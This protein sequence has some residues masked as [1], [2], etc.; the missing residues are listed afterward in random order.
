MSKIV[1]PIEA[2]RPAGWQNTMPQADSIFEIEEEDAYR[3]PNVVI[4][5]ADDLGFNDVSFYGGGVY[6][7]NVT[8]PNIDSIGHDGVSFSTAYAGHATC[9]P[10][11]A[12]LLTGRYPS[13][14]GFEFTPTHPGYV[15]ILGTSSK[16]IRKGLYY[17]EKAKGLTLEN[18]SLPS[19]TV[20]LS[21]AFKNKGYKSLMIG[22]YHLGENPL[23]HGFDETL[24]FNIISSYLPSGHKDLETFPLP[25]MLDK[26]LCANVACSVKKNG[27][28]KRF[29]PNQYMTDYFAEEAVNAIRANKEHPF[30]LYLP[31][32]APHTPLQAFKADFDS[33]SHIP[34]RL[35]RVYGAMIMAL[36]RAVG[37]ILKGLEDN[38]LTDNTIV[39]FSNDNGAPSWAMQPN[40]NAPFRG[41]KG[42]LFEGGIRVP[43]FFKWPAKIARGVVVDDPVSLIDLF[44]TVLSA[45]G[46][47]QTLA[48]SDG[49]AG[50][51]M[52]LVDGVDLLPYIAAAAKRQN[53]SVDK[54]D[55]KRP[56]TSLYWRSGHYRAIRV[57]DWKLQAALRPNKMWLYDLKNDP[58]ERNNL[59]YEPNYNEQLQEMILHLADEDSRQIDP[60]WPAITETA[61]FVDKLF[62]T[63]E[64]FEDEYVYWPN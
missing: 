46:G 60:L 15:K 18:M 59:A 47:D 11:R 55:L 13:K 32:T 8:T 58:T 54:E 25:D 64:S 27:A 40:L 44:P 3:K 1:N 51:D 48:D 42:S 28:G 35:T 19:S 9:A 12:A 62:E 23:S 50:V 45:A 41:W 10:S 52:D 6:N 31:F 5:L 36:D 14:V 17:P 33:L 57:G 43:L 61:L 63:N 24:G 22:K 4:I 21:K 38:N 53:N 30:F 20:T 37:T 56:H 49:H 39:I 29:Q 7:G 34:D 26:F 16:T 2:Y